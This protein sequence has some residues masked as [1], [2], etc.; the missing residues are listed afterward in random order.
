MTQ[1][2][3]KPERSAAFVDAGGETCFPAARGIPG[4]RGVV[5]RGFGGRAA[6]EGEAG[7]REQEQ[8]EK[9]A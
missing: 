6:A 9:E 5:I 1:M 4:A 8:A 2:G 3:K 7:A